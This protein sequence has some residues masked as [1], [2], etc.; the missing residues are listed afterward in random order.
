MSP[1]AGPWQKMAAMNRGN[2][3]LSATLR[4]T[5]EGT[6]GSEPE[7]LSLPEAD[8]VHLWHVPLGDWT[9]GGKAS[10]EAAAQ[11][12][13]QTLS[14]EEKRRA[15]AFLAAPPRLQ[16]IQTR[17]ALRVLLSRYLG[18]VP[19]EL[20]LES[21]SHGKPHLAPVHGTRLRFNVSH[22]SAHALCAFAWD[23]EVGVDIEAHSIEVDFLPVAGRVCCRRELELI[24]AANGPQRVAAFYR[25][26]SRKEAVVKATGEGLSMSLLKLIDVTSGRGEVSVT[27]S[28]SFQVADLDVGRSH[29]A[30]V[31]VLRVPR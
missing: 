19:A 23:R 17:S 24:R 30:A 18:L 2:L 7:R 4:G 22:T 28:G 1:Q 15:D 26:W 10:S 13:G 29:S 21:G 25:C 8:A 14:V 27:G 3:Q 20:R 16:F 9:V 5:C 31:A 12:F 11:S 6:G